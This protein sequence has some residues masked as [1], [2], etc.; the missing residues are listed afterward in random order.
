MVVK[1]GKFVYA[2]DA[3][4]REAEVWGS[5]VERLR[6][7]CERILGCHNC[8]STM[9]DNIDLSIFQD[10]RYNITELHVR[11]IDVQALV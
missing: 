2:M 9:K 7:S 6:V 10:L 11:M 8:I 5:L 3:M 1:K 4:S